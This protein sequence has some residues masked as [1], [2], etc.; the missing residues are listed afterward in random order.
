MIQD[1]RAE[2]EGLHVVQDGMEETDR[3]TRIAN[4]LLRVPH[5]WAHLPL[6]ERRQL[7][8]A[9]CIKQSEYSAMPLRPPA[10]R[11]MRRDCVF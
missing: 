3:P 4:S 11:L 5:G 7:G 9:P 6:G 8:E 10:F 1:Q 2:L